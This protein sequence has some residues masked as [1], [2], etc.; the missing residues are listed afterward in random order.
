MLEKYH[1]IYCQLAE[2]TSEEFMRLLSEKEC[3][4]AIYHLIGDQVPIADLGV[5]S[6]VIAK[7][8]RC[9]IRTVDMLLR[10]YETEW[11]T[12]SSYLSEV[13]Y[14]LED[15]IRNLLSLLVVPEQEEQQ[16]LL[17]EEA[18]VSH[19]ESPERTQDLETVALGTPA[20]VCIEHDE[21]I[22]KLNLSTRSFNAL[23]RSGIHMLS[24]LLACTEEDMNKIRNLGAKSKAEIQETVQRFLVNS[25]FDNSAPQ[26]P[27]KQDI[28]E[29][30]KEIEA[31]DFDRW[32]EMLADESCRNA[33][34]RFFEVN[35]CSIED[36]DLSLRSLLELRR[37]GI[38]QFSDMLMPYSEIA[39]IRN[40]RTKQRVEICSKIENVLIA[41]KK[42]L[43]EYL[44]TGVIPFLDNGLIAALE[45]PISREEIQRE[46]LSLYRTGKRFYGYSFK[47]FRENVPERV[48]DDELR[49]AVSDLLQQGELE[50]VDFR[51]YR[52]YP[53]LYDFI[54]SYPRLPD[55][56]KML[57]I[58]RLE[59]RSTQEL[60]EKYAVSRQV[61]HN[62]ESA[63]VKKLRG[64]TFDEEYY[65]GLYRHYNIPKQVW[66][67][68][69]G[70]S[71]MVLNCLR[72]LHGNSR[73]GDP[74]N[75]LEDSEVP[76]NLK[77]RLQ[78]FLDTRKLQMPAKLR[79]RTRSFQDAHNL[80]VNGQAVKT[81]RVAFEKA[82]LMHYCKDE[83]TFEEFAKLYNEILQYNQFP[84]DHEFYLTESKMKSKKSHLS[85]LPYVLWKQGERLRYYDMDKYDF[86]EL[87]ETINLGQF[88]NTELSANKFMQEYPDLMEQY[89]IRDEYELHSVLKKIVDPATCHEISFH[90]Q[91]IIRFGEYD[92]KEAVLALITEL[93]P[94]S[95][96][97]LI[98][99]L[100][101]R[102]GFSEE[103]IRANCITDFSHLYHRG[104]Y[105]VDFKTM[106]DD[107]QNLF[108]EALTEP[109]YTFDELKDIYQELFLD[110]DLQEINPR[111][112]KQ[113]GFVVNSNYVIQYYKTAEEYIT[114]VLTED[115]ILDLGALRKKF[116]V[117][118]NTFYIA[119]RKLCDDHELF[120]FDQNRLLHFRRLKK[121]GITK[122]MLRDFCDSAIGLV[123][124][125]QFFTIHMLRRNGF[126]HPLDDLGLDDY[127]YNALLLTSPS[128]SG[129][130]CFGGLVLCKVKQEHSLSRVDFI[131]S[132]LRGKIS[133][134]TEEL[135]RSIQ[136]EYGVR[137]IKEKEHYKLVQF[138]AEA[139][140]KLGMYF[141]R[142]MDKV[143]RDKSYYFE[144][145]EKKE[146]EE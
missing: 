89:D 76:V 45:P 18:L 64:Y 65:S 88:R 78:N 129:F 92:R 75:V 47:E 119:L 80:L 130:N 3:K 20:A 94:V 135:E 62:R 6:N 41:V 107:R 52:V 87:L 35:Q 12:T 108:R 66:L 68:Q 73:K 127:F 102:F 82:V 100:Q 105:T 4:S 32:E 57:V 115:D 85:A 22:E 143:Y 137:I 113:L 9:G 59:G 71:E 24:Q 126:T 138:I 27:V 133:I 26:E 11:C 5:N 70:C 116:E 14:K 128:V 48:T 38:N 17:A 123:A 146:M 103:M 136:R 61:L 145:L 23:K 49:T 112:M 43:L 96:A 21:P 81:N 28:P 98:A 134:S 122:D 91:P 25:G 53:K 101:K 95:T 7:L 8:K 58:D 60:M 77:Y 46:L 109:F 142:T 141:D 13:S 15:Y 83:M 55:D 140:E 106:S 132:M 34:I 114:H 36:L 131:A 67:E 44:N 40:V 118:Q 2:A 72:F 31:E 121:M 39:R 74:E 99:E 139:S 86:S 69:L 50:Y 54:L 97:D 79:Y 30:L 19:T 42:D 51:C 29:K 33:L 63:I 104:Y 90:R 16:G 93:S 84:E 37:V 120:Y 111:M 125:G 56:R 10:Y 110:G 117:C 124:D 144:D 1:S